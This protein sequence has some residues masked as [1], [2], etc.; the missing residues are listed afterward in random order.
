MTAKEMLAVFS[1][2]QV[3]ALNLWQAVFPVWKRRTGETRET[4]FPALQSLP[5][6]SGTSSMAG[7]AAGTIE[8]P[9]E[10]GRRAAG[11]AEIAESAGRTAF[12]LRMPGPVEDSLMRTEERDGVLPVSGS[13]RR[14]LSLW[15]EDTGGTIGGSLAGSGD[16]VF[17]RLRM[18]DISETAVLLSG[19]REQAGRSGGMDAEGIFAELERRLAIELGAR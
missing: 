10:P 7:P 1:G 6:F 9:A 5:G 13:V 4:S 16:A 11:L 12:R 18:G 19:L 8:N 15:R 17:R 3:P 14:G 2:D